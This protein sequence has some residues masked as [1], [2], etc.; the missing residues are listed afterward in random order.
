M[1]K[2][3]VPYRKTGYFSSLICDLVDHHSS[4]SSFVNHFASLSNFGPQ[5]KQKEKSFS[6]E[7]RQTL[8]ESLYQQNCELPKNK[9]V[10]S[11]I[12]LLK[13]PN[14]FTVTTGHQLNLFTGPL[15]FIYKILST[16]NTCTE[17]KKQYPQF[18]FVPLY[19]MA[20]EDHDFEE[21]SFFRFGGKKIKWNTSAH[22]AV[23][24]M[25]VKSLTPLLNLFEKNL[26]KSISAEQLK[27]W[28]QHS[29]RKAS[30][31]AEA[32]RYLV[33]HLFGDSGLITL[34]ADNALLKR[35]LIPYVENDLFQHACN[36]HVLQSIAKLKEV[37][38]TDY[39]PQ[40]N[41]REIN[42]FYLTNS[43]RQR[44]VKRDGGF[45]TADGTLN[46]TER[47]IR[48]QLKDF[49]ER[50]SPNVLMRP[51]YQE[52]ILPNLAYIG[53]GG[54]IAYWIELKQFFDNQNIPFPILMLRN[55][56]LLLSEKSANKSKRLHLSMEDL[57]LPRTAL[58]NKKIRQISN[59]D[60]DLQPLKEKLIDQFDYLESLV[61][62]TDMSFEGAVKA[63]KAKQFKGIDQLEKRLLQAQKRKLIDHV[64]RLSS[65][66][67]SLFPA[68]SLQERQDNFFEYY[69]SYGDKL[70][71]KLQ[72]QL[73]PFNQEFS[74]LILTD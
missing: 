16:I 7:S 73:D 3:H 45:S 21:I 36:K 67:E 19:W 6:Q 44:L 49:P 51:L 58:I 9:K 17:L 1:K 63:Q 4:L 20:T 25:S 18:D 62:Q 59:I 23:G 28:I 55:S 32:T 53:G 12:D 56:A 64:S 74:C 5:I 48:A 8:A 72:A 57:F 30:N 46:F 50:F 15:Y 14:T 29:Y 2:I 71:P 22:G 70:L 35:A 41:P 31:L 33:H 34:D 60:L 40:V 65:L 69:L 24:R 11:N 10:L 54:E 27:E 66:Q 52:L 68:E 37:Y 42:F 39:K 43:T 47:E 61:E 13:K 26:G 38:A